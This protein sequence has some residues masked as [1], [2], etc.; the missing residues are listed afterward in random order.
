MI[1]IITII[2]IIMTHLLN[3]T[4]F[5]LFLKGKCVFNS[6]D[7][8]SKHKYPSILESVGLVPKSWDILHLCIYE[9]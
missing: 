4:V 7:F 6:V 9:R 5:W 8:M 3:H 1:Y 2:L